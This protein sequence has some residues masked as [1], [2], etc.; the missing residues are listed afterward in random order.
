MTHK[1]N[2]CH[3]VK[4]VK[5][6]KRAYGREKQEGMRDEV[7]KLSEIGFVREV[8]IHSSWLILC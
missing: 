5:Q 1:L 2:V 6:K 3:N 7:E 8:C 4:L